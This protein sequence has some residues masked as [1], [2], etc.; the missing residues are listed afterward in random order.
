MIRVLVAEDSAVVRLHL[1]D[2]I[3][4]DGTMSVVGAAADGE[5]AVQLA[6]R[7]RPDVILCDIHM[8]H[9]DGYAAARRI[10]ELAPAPI[11]MATAS[12]SPSDAR[13]AFDAIQAGAL[14]LVEKPVGPGHPR[15]DEAARELI[16]TLRLMSEVKVVRRWRPGAPR[17]PRAVAARTRPRVIALGASTGGPAVVA[18]LLRGLPAPCPCPVLVAQHITAGFTEAFADWLAVATE[19]RVELA[20]N[21]VRAQA[22]TV[23]VAPSGAHL[24]ITREGV[25][26]LR[27]PTGDDRFCP[28]V[29][30]LFAAVADAYG[31]AAVGVVLTGM[32]HDGADGLARLRA[33][34]GLTIAQDKASSVVF[35][36]P[37]AAI[38]AG[39]A[40]LVLPPEGIAEALAST[41][42]GRRVA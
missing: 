19:R 33:A 34:G 37:A 6:V 31:R 41:L 12:A 38:A 17:Q 42:A 25:L 29:S 10:M 5:E 16:R 21:G 1:T 32:G 40:E 36:M 9:L 24:A 8:P 15:A 20:R 23:Y 30:R 4:S 39:A 14:V 26:T 7:L 27:P 11:V 13:A 28:S 22:D 35:G 3:E 2:V 18:D